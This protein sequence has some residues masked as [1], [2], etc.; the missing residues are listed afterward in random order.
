MRAHLTGKSVAN[1]W[2]YITLISILVFCSAYFLVV[3]TTEFFT[4]SGTYH[5]R[6]YDFLA[7]YSA[8]HFVTSGDIAQ[9]YSA[10]AMTSFERTIVPHPVSALGYMPFLNPP[11]M[12]VIIAPLSLLQIND[13]RLIWMLINLSLMAWLAFTLTKSVGSRYMRAL[14]MFLIIASYPVLQNLIQ[15]QISIFI[16]AGCLLSLYAYENKKLMTSGALLS[17]LAIKPQLALFVGLGLVLFRQWRMIKGL[18]LATL[19]LVVLSLPFTGFNLYVTYIEFSRAVASGHF[20]GAGVLEPAAWQGSLSYAFGLNGAYTSLF[21]QSNVT[22]VNIFTLV[23]GGALLALLLITFKK[24]KPGLKTKSARLVLAASLATLL[25]IN[26]HAY[27]HDLILAFVILAILTPVAKVNILIPAFL[28]FVSLSYI[29]DKYGLHFTTLAL[30]SFV[31]CL[32][33]SILLKRK[34]TK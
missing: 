7:F 18:L 28:A 31:L 16:L 5:G 4:G 12:A 33:V 11:F 32:A 14:Y 26:P 30:V 10:S 13:S 15:G 27:A 1:K 17:V 8:A 24:Q 25:L 21:G 34:N 3:F 6:H 2:V 19:A 9:I 20:T 22:M 23:T 29:D